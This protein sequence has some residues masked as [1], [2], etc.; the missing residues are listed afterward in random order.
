MNPRTCLCHYCVILVSVLSGCSNQASSPPT[1]SS[2]APDFRITIRDFYGVEGYWFDY[3]IVPDAV[4]VKHGDDFGSPIT[5]VYESNLLSEQRAELGRAIASLDVRRLNSD[6]SNPNV[7]DG[8]Q[9]TFEI[10][11]DNSPSKKIFVGNMNQPDLQK[12][13]HSINRFIPL[14]R[15]QIR[16]AWDEPGNAFIAGESTSQESDESD[17]AGS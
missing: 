15:Y 4:R 17:D 6:Y 5:P 3:E 10:S 2:H 16:E 13:V 9:I 11:I 7:S 14:V 1:S 12:L 8:V